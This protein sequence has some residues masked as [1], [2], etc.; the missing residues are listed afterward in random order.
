MVLTSSD[1]TIDSGSPFT[2]TC[3]HSALTDGLAVAWMKGSA[4][5]ADGFTAASSTTSVLTVAS[6]DKDDNGQYFCKV[7][8]GEYGSVVKSMN[9]YVRY[10]TPSAT[11]YG[12]AGENY[13]LICVFYGD[14]LGATTWTKDNSAVTTA[15]RIT[16]TAGTMTDMK[17]T[18]TLTTTVL[19]AGDAGDYICS[20]TYTDGSAT[21]TSTQTLAI[22]E[23][24]LT[25][26]LVR[27]PTIAAVDSAVKVT[28]TCT[29]AEVTLE[30]GSLSHAWTRDG[31]AY[32][33]TSPTTTSRTEIFTLT[34]ASEDNA[35]FVC[36]V[37]F[38]SYGDVAA[39]TTLQVRHVAAASEKSYAFI[40]AT[41][42]DFVFTAYGDAPASF[43][44]KKDGVV[45]DGADAKHKETL[46]TYASNQ[47]T[48]TLKLG[49][50]NKAG[51][52]K[53]E[54][55]WANPHATLIAET[56]FSVSTVI[57]KKY[58]HITC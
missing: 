57:G 34:A 3:T 27:A 31:V 1:S 14:A 22:T 18:D 26:T 17:R 37:T 47:Q 48:L 45:L 20:A 42:I 55:T 32:T 49:E 54:V 13:D 15:G 33:P 46:G 43:V 38:G 2:L 29:W 28:F 41:G 12:V 44:W 39:T 21:K 4:V 53:C 51:T 52:Y 56:K 19:V 36:V 8:F 7:T 25:V 10:Q 6:A 50:A 23:Q 16:V 58:I 9:Q 30:S 24:S 40:D 11:V 5:I 35:D